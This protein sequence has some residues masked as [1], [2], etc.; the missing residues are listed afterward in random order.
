MK[1]GLLTNQYKDPGFEFSTTVS[2]KLRKLGCEVK[3]IY[4]KDVAEMEEQSAA[5][6]PEEDFNDC[7][8]VL[9]LGGDGTFLSAVHVSYLGETPLIGVNLGSLGFLTELYPENL[10]EDLER[11]AARDYTIEN[12]MMLDCCVDYET[13]F[14]D[15]SEN[16]QGFALNEVVLSRG[17][18]PRIL[19][20]ELWIDGSLI[21]IIPS[22]GLM[23]STPTGS[24]GYAM[25]AGGPIIQPQLDLMLIT[26]ICPHTLHNRSYIISSDSLVELKM[27]YYPYTP[28]LSIDGQHDVLLD[29]RQRIS[30]CKAK[31]PLRIA[32]L[33]EPSFFHTLPE[34]IRGRGF[35]SN[36]EERVT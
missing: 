13:E 17:N 33:H 31:R 18:S 7:D 3:I 12:R 1:V 15:M 16:H 11:I 25:A 28:V 4:Q 34:K 30:I 20:I 35:V 9:S 6:E 26:P 24:T 10:D 29:C 32:R 21:E 23:V 36:M 5:V 19:P 14:S 22:D 8:I 27:R 2:T